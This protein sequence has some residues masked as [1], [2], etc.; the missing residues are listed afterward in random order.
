MSGDYA[1][2]GISVYAR[3]QHIRQTIAALQRNHLAAESELFLF[4]DAA[5]PGDE[6]KVAEVRAYLRTVTGFR[7]VHII[8]RQENNRFL[9]NQQGRLLLLNEY[10]RAI[11]LE[12]DILTAPTFLHFMNAALE[13]YRYAPMV[14]AINGYTPPLPIPSDYRQSILLLP[15]FAAWGFAIW[16]AQF[17]EIEMNITPAMYHAIR[18]DEARCRSYCI[19]GDDI[20]SQLWL[21]AHGYINALDVRIDYSMYARGRRYVVCPA[22]SLT[23]T[24]GCDGS[25]EHWT[26][27]TTKYDVAMGEFEGW[28]PA[29]DEL[30]VDPHIL[31]GLRRFYA[32]DL[33]GRLALLTMD[34]GIY[35]YWRKLKGRYR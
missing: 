21:Q 20:L 25:G 19:G 5:R 18:D 31:A 6:T 23:Q 8:E 30:G 17:E 1:P 4:S 28:T 11:F 35:P 27:P 33:K 9:N 32:L 10:E 3:L 24:I 12:E 14:F 34:A 26:R 22:R 16:R 7:R 2:I 15:R 29:D 13:R